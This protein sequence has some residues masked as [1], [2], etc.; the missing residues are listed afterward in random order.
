VDLVA[1][2][3]RD[4]DR[5]TQPPRQGAR[6][7]P[8]DLAEQEAE[9]LGVVAKAGMLA[10]TLLRAGRACRPTQLFARVCLGRFSVSASW[11]MLEHP[12]TDP[13]LVNLASCLPTVRG[14]CELLGD[15]EQQPAAAVTGVFV[16]LL[17]SPAAVEAAAKAARGA[18]VASA[19]VWG[20]AVLARVEWGALARRRMPHLRPVQMSLPSLTAPSGQR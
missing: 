13:T 18:T 15:L 5:F 19:T 3:K 7:S 12:R 1:D 2:P 10:A 9:G 4:R 17:G 11:S 14:L 16:M 20:V 8:H 6:R